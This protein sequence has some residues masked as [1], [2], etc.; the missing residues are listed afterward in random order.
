MQ[1]FHSM[2]EIRVMG[3]KTLPLTPKSIVTR[4]IYFIKRDTLILFLSVYLD[5][6]QTAKLAALHI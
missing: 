6:Y 5:F 3:S 1:V 4:S 2:I